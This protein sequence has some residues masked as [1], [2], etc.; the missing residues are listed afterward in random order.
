MRSY[1][2]SDHTTLF[3]VENYYFLRN[4]MVTP[5]L[6]ITLMALPGSVRFLNLMVRSTLAPDR[7]LADPVCIN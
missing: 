5:T 3:P 2:L 7:D 4:E 6:I 1:Q